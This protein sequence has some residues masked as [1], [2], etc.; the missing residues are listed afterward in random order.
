MDTFDGI[1]GLDF[2]SASAFDIKN[3]VWAYSLHPSTRVH[4][5]V[6]T[7]ATCSGRRDSFTW[8]PGDELRADAVEWIVNG[9]LIL[10][11]NASFEKS[12]WENILTPTH[13]WPET[14]IEQWR[15]TQH[16]GL[17]VNQ[18]LAL[19]GLA[20]ALGCPTQKDTEGAKLMRKMMKA[21]PN[22]TGGW[23]YD[24]D[25]DHLVA[26]EAYCHCDVGAMLDSYFRLPSLSVTEALVS[27]VDQRINSRGVYL[28]QEFAARCAVLVDKRS[29][30]LAKEVF[31]GTDA[32]LSDSKA[33]P[34]L[35]TWLKDLG[36]VLPKVTRKNTKGEFKQVETADRSAVLGLLDDPDLPAEART[37]LE[38]RMEANKATSLAK[39]K[40][41]PLM[42]GIDG[43]LRHALTYMGALT[44]RWTSLGLQLHNWPKDQMGEGTR[45]LVRLSLALGDLDA[46]KMATESPLDAISQSLRSVIAAPRGC[47]LIGGDFSAVE[48]RGIAWLAGQWDILEE[49]AAGTDVYAYTAAKIGSSS[50]SLGKVCVLALGYQMGAIKFAAT[51]AKHGVHLD[52]K[53]AVRIQKFWRG[54][55]RA[56]VGFWRDLEDTARDAI[57]EPGVV[58][59]V[60]SSTVCAARPQDIF[61]RVRK[62][63]LQVL[64]PSGRS[65]RY[66]RPRVVRTVKMIKT[67][68]DEG[69]IVEREM[70]T[71]EIRFFTMAQDK[72][73]MR[74]E[75]TYGGKL[76]E[77]VTQA[78]ARDLLAEALVR[79]DP[80]DPY[81]LVMHVHDSIVSEVPEGAGSVQEFCKI[82]AVAPAW[83]DG[84]PIAVEG[85]RAKR[86][87][88]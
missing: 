40:R 26:L 82:M 11:H 1:L 34:T 10:A 58:L 61:M 87:R 16:L 27:R 84:L 88:G 7:F 76:A 9:G 54:T 4:L 55:N 74:L 51:A 72:K 66:W 13:D 77:N 70:H 21:D 73:T 48:A 3:G 36:V 32:W 59:R 53:Q 49:F 2:E 57:A 63:C 19:E 18:P 47:D 81:Q 52:L 24:R 83:A 37:V 20:R 42:V 86:F 25:F 64:L 50:R 60:G 80:V 35:K 71:D 5:A 46:L 68:N 17:A 75:S 65:I 8:W 45:A 79:I 39:L 78:V 15:D 33:A 85:Y 23:I 6:F 30:E 22:D 62:D 31:L 29:A 38:N 41:V 12:M 56:I 44:G 14:S 28:D 43:R 67:V 69:E